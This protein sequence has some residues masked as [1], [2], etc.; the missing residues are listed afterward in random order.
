MTETVLRSVGFNGC[1]SGACSCRVVSEWAGRRGG[2]LL[3]RLCRNLCVS[4]GRFGLS[5]GEMR[6]EMRSHGCVLF[7]CQFVGHGT[8]R[9]RCLGSRKQFWGTGEILRLVALGMPL[10]FQMNLLQRFCQAESLR[11]EYFFA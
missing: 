6:G 8:R 5:M 11:N 10:A 3:S 7:T 4:V 1:I 9:E 2:D